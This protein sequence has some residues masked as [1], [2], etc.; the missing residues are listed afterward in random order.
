MGQ[1]L[2]APLHLDSYCPCRVDNVAAFGRLSNRRF[3][4]CSGT[5]R[6]HMQHLLHETGI[7]SSQARAADLVADL[8]VYARLHVYTKCAAVQPATRYQISDAEWHR[9]SVGQETS[10]LGRHFSTLLASVAIGCQSMLL[11]HVRHILISTPADQG[12]CR[13]SFPHTVAWS[14]CSTAVQCVLPSRTPRRPIT[15]ACSLARSL[16]YC[17]S[18]PSPP[19]LASRV[20]AECSRHFQAP[21]YHSR[22]W[23]STAMLNRD[24]AG[25]SE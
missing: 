10:R 19:S 22:H 17:P 21:P 7:E 14:L 16:C 25:P 5:E 4:G 6:A 8:R 20:H 23:W 15:V 12:T 9:D 3:G 13:S 24:A 1:A 18:R 11:L 2:E